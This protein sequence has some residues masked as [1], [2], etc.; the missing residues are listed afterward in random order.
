MLAAHRDFEAFRG[1]N[2]A[3]LMSWLREI[4]LE[5]LSRDVEDSACNLASLSPCH[6]MN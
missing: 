6:P 1:E 5:D 4:S 3:K 2:L